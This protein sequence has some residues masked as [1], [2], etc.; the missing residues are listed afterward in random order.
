MSSTSVG[1]FD[2]GLSAPGLDTSAQLIGDL[3]VRGAP[4]WRAGRHHGGVEL[5]PAELALRATGDVGGAARYLPPPPPDLAATSA[6]SATPQ[7]SAVAAPEPV[8]DTSATFHQAP[9]GPTGPVADTS[10]TPSLSATALTRH[11]ALVADV[12]APTPPGRRPGARA[13]GRARQTPWG[14]CELQPSAEGRR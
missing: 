3:L 5:Q 2:P 4:S 12:A 14:A 9:P 10:A 7:V 6:T 1:S 11:V 8:A 13:G